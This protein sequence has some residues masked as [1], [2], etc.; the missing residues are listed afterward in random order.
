[1]MDVIVIGAGAAGLMAAYTLTRHGKKVIVLEA[2]NRCGG[3]I[4]TI[5]QQPHLELGAEFVHGNLPVTLNLLQQAGIKYHHA[6]G[7]MWQYKKGS[8]T[9]KDEP[10]AGWDKLIEKLNKL[11]QDCSMTEF[12]KREFGGNEYAELRNSVNRYV[13]GYDTADPNRAS[14]MALKTEW[15]NE[16]EDAQYRI[17]G[18][19]QE[20]INYL[21]DEIRSAGSEIHLN[22]PINRVQWQAG[23]ANA[24]T[25]DGLEYEARHMLIALPLGVLQADG[26]RFEPPTPQQQS[27][28]NK[29][30]YGAIIKVLLQFKEAFW[31]DKEAGKLIGRDPKNMGFILSD[32][33][34][35]TW[36]TQAPLHN[37]VLTGWLG[38]PNAATKKDAGEEEILNEAIN[39][40]TNIF[41]RDAAALKSK[42]QISHIVN[43]TND[44]YTR[45][46]YAYDTMD[47][48]SS[49]QLL[50]KG[51]SE[52]LFFAGE[53]F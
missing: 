22:L 41:K 38:G 12:L 36:W 53:Y 21:A 13:A 24:I 33:P 50:N 20:M 9:T 26:L 6:G 48:A 44:P 25:V 19:Y 5:N 10:I 47:S 52:T 17:D 1:M 8:F 27:A 3:R 35:P 39:S 32:Q 15:Q 2:R 23:K 31:E 34:I 40:L 14:A 16:D 46:S 49:R 4:H 29:M 45:G 51:V 11:Q 30:G 37:N 7:E 43:W 28:I 42:L 18:G